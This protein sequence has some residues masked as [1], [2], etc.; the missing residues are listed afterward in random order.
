MLL[1]VSHCDQSPRSAVS[2]DDT[3]GDAEQS[4]LLT[5][6]FATAENSNAIAAILQLLNMVTAQ[7]TIVTIDAVA[8]EM[9]IQE[10]AP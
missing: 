7:G 9:R 4:V 3:G 8:M 1:G 10:S 5:N 6:P 2:T